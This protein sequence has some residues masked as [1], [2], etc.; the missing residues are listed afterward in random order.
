MSQIPFYSE[1]ASMRERRKNFR[2]EWNSPAQIYDGKGRFVTSCVVSNFSN[3]G[4]KIVGVE[5]N[6]IPDEFIL[7]I[8][9]RSR[10]HECTVIW[11]S[12][13]RLGV[14]F[15]GYAKV[16]NEPANRSG[17]SAA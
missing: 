17:A 14:K 2:V 5:P 6:T 1:T 7:R 10:P 12:K 9:P 3:S 11:R 15:N 8:S 13:D 4:A 16:T